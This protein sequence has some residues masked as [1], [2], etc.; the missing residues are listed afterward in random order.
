M[1]L[2]HTGSEWKPVVLAKSGSSTSELQMLVVDG[3]DQH[4]QRATPVDFRTFKD[5]GDE[6]LYTEENLQKREAIKHDPKMDRIVS[7]FWHVLDMQKDEQEHISRRVYTQLNIRLHK[8]LIPDIHMEEA[9][10]EA[11]ADWDRDCNGLSTMPYDN[12]FHAMFELA[13]LWCLA[14]DIERYVKFLEQVF[15]HVMELGA[16]G[17]YRWREVNNI[18]FMEEETREKEEEEAR[19]EAEEEARR[20]AAERALSERQEKEAREAR[21]HKGSV[22]DGQCH[23]G[24][25]SIGSSKGY[26]NGSGEGSSSSGGTSGTG[27]AGMGGRNDGVGINGIDGI[28]EDGGD[29]RVG[30][31]LSAEERESLHAEE[32]QKRAAEAERRKNLREKAR[33]ERSELARKRLEEREERERLDRERKQQQLL[34][35]LANARRRSLAALE[36][37]PEG[38]EWKPAAMIRS[39]HGELSDESVRATAAIRAQTATH[40]SQGRHGGTGPPSPSSLS[41]AERSSRQRYA[42]R[43]GSGGS[44]SGSRSGS[45]QINVGKSAG[46][47]QTSLPAAAEPGASFFGSSTSTE[48]RPCTTEMRYRRVDTSAP[49]GD[50]VQFDVGS[51]AFLAASRPRVSSAVSTARPVHEAPLLLM[52]TEKQEQLYRNYESRNGGRKYDLV[53]DTLPRLDAPKGHARTF[54][55]FSAPKGQDE[56]A[57]RLWPAIG[58]GVANAA[59][60]HPLTTADNGMRRRQQEE[61]AKKA[62]EERAWR[63]QLKKSG[64][65]LQLPPAA[66][67][68]AAAAGEAG[69]PSSAKMKRTKA[70]ERVATRAATARARRRRLRLDEKGDSASNMSSSR[71]TQGSMSSPI[72]SGRRKLQRRKRQPGRKRGQAGLP[73]TGSDPSSPMKLELLRREMSQLIN[74]LPHTQPLNPTNQQE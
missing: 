18:D 72:T 67:V 17:Q 69:L 65:P 54:P 56:P 52:S 57:Q 1:A 58:G 71:H 66:V 24:S 37:P 9:V 47:H 39:W 25:Q 2:A 20:E 59:A 31:Q 23:G 8:A 22:A 21:M 16:D 33:R 74:T 46:D 29:G 27:R 34:E 4:D 61:Q 49:P 14:I 41:A 60:T 43:Y 13:D 64:D 35:K 48:M 44:R 30:Q 63:Q 19:R 32:L 26:S 28:I 55:P 73:F 62:A 51:L 40:F 36:E 3:S 6:E 10:E 50:D 7:K 15:S 11:D 45:R 38:Q 42:A 70:A 5:E 12:F 68:V 53:D